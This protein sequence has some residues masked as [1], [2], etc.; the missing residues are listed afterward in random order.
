MLSRRW[1]LHLR[2]RMLKVRYGQHWLLAQTLLYGSGV[3]KLAN[4]DH[5][6]LL[7]HSQ[8]M[9]AEKNP[10]LISF[11]VGMLPVTGHRGSLDLRLPK[12]LVS[13]KLPA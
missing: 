4:G 8:P 12:N 1:R 3:R 10:H 2:Q 5:L 13:H 9:S 11:Y 7:P 6:L